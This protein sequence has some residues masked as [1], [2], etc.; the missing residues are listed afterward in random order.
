MAAAKKIL[1]LGATS[2]IAQETARNF[3]KDKSDFYLVSRSEEK[4]EEVKSDLLVK[5]AA[6]V[7]IESAALAEIEKHD[8]LFNNINSKFPGFDTVLLA[9]GSL[10]DQERCQNDRTLALKELGINFTS[11]ISLLT[12]IANYFEKN[13]K[14]TIA[15][16]TSVAGDRGRKKNYIYGAAK[17]GLNV[18]LQ[19]LRNRFGKTNIKVL[20]VKPGFVDTPMTKDFKKGPLFAGADKVGQDIY[21]A[22]QKEK[23]SIYSPAFWGII[24]LIIK[25][26]PERFFKKLNI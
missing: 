26:I 11:A 20:T 1:I 17:A 18:Y 25:S 3:A 21:Q 9:Y 15:V 6:S 10:S 16:I 4:L 24:M 5:G 22:I 19:G 14:G 7:L 12:L 2:L 8:T 23:D 13:G